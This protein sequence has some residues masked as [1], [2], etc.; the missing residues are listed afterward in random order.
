[1]P[2]SRPSAALSA[3]AQRRASLARRRIPKLRSALRIP[4]AP[5]APRG[6]EPG[7]RRGVGCARTRHDPTAKRC[8]PRSHLRLQ[9]RGG[10]TRGLEGKIVATAGDI[11]VVGPQAPSLLGNARTLRGFGRL[12]GCCSWG[13][14]LSIPCALWGGRKNRSQQLEK[15]FVRTALPSHA[16]D[17]GYACFDG[18]GPQCASCL[19]PL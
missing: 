8:A 5:S 2:S 16:T 18:A 1:M 12:C 4:T 17:G 9:A 7:P 6:A 14:L 15:L 13:V 10:R 19:R 3:A 11:A